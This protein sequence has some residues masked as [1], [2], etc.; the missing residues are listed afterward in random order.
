MESVNLFICILIS[1]FPIYLMFGSIGIQIED[2]IFLYYDKYEGGVLVSIL[3]LLTFFS[4]L[5][6]LASTIR[7][8]N[9]VFQNWHFHEKVKIVKRKNTLLGVLLSLIINALIIFSTIY[10]IKL[11][12]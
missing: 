12:H 6:L 1:P 9:G 7:K 5:F 3:C 4:L 2:F 10:I 11:I 8:M